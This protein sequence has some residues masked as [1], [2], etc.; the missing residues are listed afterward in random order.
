M[1]TSLAI[2]IIA[3]IFS[4]VLPILIAVINNKYETKKWI[5]EHYEKHRS[6]VIEQYLNVVSNY[7]FYPTYDKENDLGK[8]LSEIYMYIPK[9]MWDKIE[10]LNNLLPEHNYNS[11]KAKELFNQLCKEFSSLR[12]TNKFKI[13]KYKQ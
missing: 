6:E 7:I 9:N 1:D 3:L 12:R 10:E 2:S 4:F 8:V 13:S 11:E 5:F